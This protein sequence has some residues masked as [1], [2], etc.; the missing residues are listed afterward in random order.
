MRNEHDYEPYNYGKTPEIEEPKLDDNII[1]QPQFEEEDIFVEEPKTD[2]TYA[3]KYSNY[4]EYTNEQ[5]KHQPES[6]KKKKGGFKKFLGVVALA[7]VFGLVASGIFVGATKLFG[8]FL[9]VDMNHDNTVVGNTQISEGPGVEVASGIADV[10][11]NVMPSVV[12]IT[13]MSIQEVQNFFFGTQEYKSESRGSGIII[14][15]NEK[16]LLIVT[17]Y[18]VIE[19]GTTLTVTFNDD[20][21]V[22]AHVKGTEPKRDLAILAVNLDN[23]SAETKNA[24]SIATLGNS[25]TIR[26]GET[27][28]AIG[29]ALGYG[30]SV[31]TGI[32]SALDRTL[33]DYEGELIQT[34]A[35]INQGNSGGALLNAKGEVIG[36]NSAKLYGTSVESMGYA[37]PISD[38]KDILNDLMNRE[39]KVKVAEN[40]RGSIGIQGTTVDETYSQIYNMPE[41]VFVSQVLEGGGAEKAGL[42][43]NCVITKLN[44]TSI[45]TME[46]LIAELEY[47]EVG[48][49]VELTVQVPGRGGYTEEKI[50]VTLY[51]MKEQK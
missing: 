20:T 21:N 4:Y 24:I 15:Q 37:I 10:V 44:G 13:N 19:N 12:A 34:D 2:S 39:T 5:P 9:E 16:E 31:T 46:E 1:D 45:S 40:K 29:N 51:K 14:G 38:V 11:E 48:E 26:V 47:Y 36:I 6:P 41:G 17:N 33:E 28:I 35:A 43:A 7:V 32:V 42:E 50:D 49:T 27:T 22:E 8:E 18:H 23:I 30:L 3:Y 25:D